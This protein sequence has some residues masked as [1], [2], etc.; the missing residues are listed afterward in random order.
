M[1]G[2]AFVGKPHVE[3]KVS[4]LDRNE[5]NGSTKMLNILNKAFN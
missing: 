4:F 5:E 1:E 3:S 2:C